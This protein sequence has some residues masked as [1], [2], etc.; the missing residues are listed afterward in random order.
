VPSFGKAHRLTSYSAPKQPTTLPNLKDLT[1]DFWPVEDFDLC[2]TNYR[3]K[4]HLD[5]EAPFALV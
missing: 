2:S 5:L 4:L 3:V 1:A